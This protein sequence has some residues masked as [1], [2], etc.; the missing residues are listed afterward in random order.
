VARDEIW[1]AQQLFLLAKGIRIA[2][3]KTRGLAQ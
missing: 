2:G 3:I 1:L